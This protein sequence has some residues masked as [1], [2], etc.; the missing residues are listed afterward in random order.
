MV[1]RRDPTECIRSQRTSQKILA[2]LR[3]SFSACICCGFDQH[4][5]SNSRAQATEAREAGSS[6]LKRHLSVGVAD[7]DAWINMRDLAEGLAFDA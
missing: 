7:D 1:E 2:R 5:R 4:A 3:A 6:R